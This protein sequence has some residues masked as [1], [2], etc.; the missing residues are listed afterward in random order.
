MSRGL[1]YF[2]HS[3]L[4]DIQA[5]PARCCMPPL[6]VL[7]TSLK[8]RTEREKE[9]EK[10]RDIHDAL[11]ESPKPYAVAMFFFNSSLI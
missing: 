2:Q 8:F 6:A 1:A 9:R 11:P 5:L 10:E 3:F 4:L 7:L